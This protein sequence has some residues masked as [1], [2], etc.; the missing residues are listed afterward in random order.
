MLR[1]CS[2][3][4]HTHFHRYGGRGITVCERW[5]VFE[6]FLEDMGE[7]PVGRSIDRI[8]NDGNYEPG[9]C[10]W[11]TPQEQM[12]NTSVSRAL[13]VDGT[14][15]PLVEWAAIRG[16]KPSTIRERLRRGWTA[17]EALSVPPIPRGRPTE[18]YRESRRTY[19]CFGVRRSFGEWAAFAGLLPVT[20]RKR[21][22]RGMSLAEAIAEPLDMRQSARSIGGQREGR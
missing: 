1:R 10:R 21:L 14:T 3:A 17:K 7:R 2:Y 5:L 22:E 13:T 9:N 15:R 11:A 19:E 20:L 12:R 4:K 18:R 8:D 6:N 16:L